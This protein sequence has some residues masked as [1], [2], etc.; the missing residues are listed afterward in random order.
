MACVFY[1][2]LRTFFHPLYV[3]VLKSWQRATND[4]ARSFDNAVELELLLSGD[5]VKPHNDGKCKNG[6][7]DRPIKVYQYILCH[8]EF[9]KLS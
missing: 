3:N 5:T 7:N 8:I 4:F 1:D 2:L 9:F 6:F